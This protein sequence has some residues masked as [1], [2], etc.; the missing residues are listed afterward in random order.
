MST[1][2]QRER[3]AYFQLTNYVRKG[4]PKSRERLFI[5][6]RLDRDT[7]GVLVFARSER[8]QSFLRDHWK[9][10]R[11]TYEAIVHG[12]PA[13]EAGEVRCRLAENKAHRVYVAPGA[14]EGRPTHTRWR[15][16]AVGPSRSGLEID[17]ITGHK[18]QI[19]VH[20]AHIGHPVAGDR[21]YGPEPPEARRLAL[22][23]RQIVFPHPHTGAEMTFASPVPSVFE[24]ILKFTPEK[25]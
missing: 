13:D 8:A 16:K 15:R 18:H 19:R 3:T 24:S 17:L 21:K 9:Q 10:V 14:T 20:L 5:V 1:A 23:A 11:K 25:A 2:R 12:H 4:N 7:S 22:H 6:H